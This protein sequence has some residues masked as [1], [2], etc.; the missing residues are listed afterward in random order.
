LTECPLLTVDGVKGIDVAWL[1]PG[2][3]EL[4]TDELVLR[5]APEICAEIRS[6][7]NSTPEMNE[8][9]TL[10]FE[11]GAREVW[12]VDLTGQI[13]FFVPEPADRSLI[14][15]PF[16]APEN[17]PDREKLPVRPPLP[18]NRQGQARSTWRTSTSQSGELKFCGQGE[19]GRI[20]LALEL[21]TQFPF[22]IVGPGAFRHQVRPM[23]NR[24]GLYWI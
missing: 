8:K 18:I 16:N 23:I 2:R 6:T 22:V 11:A 15:P 10:Y 20:G 24:L 21:S 13:S 9:R 12:I 4:E 19:I 5:R 7:G 1:A 3:T 14:C 17:K